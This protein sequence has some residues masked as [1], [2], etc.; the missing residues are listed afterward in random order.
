MYKGKA[1]LRVA[2]PLL[3][4]YAGAK[5]TAKRSGH[6]ART[7]VAAKA[8]RPAKGRRH[9]ALHAMQDKRRVTLISDESTSL[10][11]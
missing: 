10:N 7:N 9:F 5:K 6:H 11:L 3:G 4:I 1:T 8:S 2:S